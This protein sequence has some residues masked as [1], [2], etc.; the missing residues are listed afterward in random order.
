MPKT[1]IN[2]F[3]KPFLLLRYY[4]LYGGLGA[5]VF[6]LLLIFSFTQAERMA[7]YDQYIQHLTA[8]AQILYQDIDRDF[9]APRQVELGGLA[10]GPPALLRELDA[11]LDVLVRSDFNLARVKLFSA[12]GITLYDHEH[13]E[14]L[15]QRYAS[16]GEPGFQSALQGRAASSLEVDGNGR[17]MEICLPVLA[18]GT[19]RVLGVLELYEDVGRFEGQVYLAL[20]QALLA[21]TLIFVVFNLILAL[22][23][24]KADRIIAAET[25]L[26]HAIRQNMEK[27]LSR[28]AIEA[29][30]TAV[31]GKLHLFT[32]KRQSLVVWFS[33]IRGFTAFSEQNEPEKVVAE[34]NRIL[35]LQEEIIHREGGVVDKFIGDAV[36]ATFAA[37]AAESA[38]RVGL[39]V[40]A[41]VRGQKDLP[42]RLGIGIHA[43]DAVVGTIGSDARRDYT[44]IGDTVNT[45]SRLCG[46]ASPGEVVISGEVCRELSPEQASRFKPRHLSGL[47]G[48]AAAIEAF[49]C[50]GEEY[51]GPPLSG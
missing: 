27:Y 29:I 13:P 34:L 9:L 23:V 21:P 39:A 40:L 45:A 31:S 47:K 4:L 11:E 5:V 36:M 51:S 37:D 26:L 7:L 12:E 20:R 44:A 24:A 3:S 1:T 30:W 19:N 33:D 28:S 16:W 50:C 15:G 2:P 42:F 46:V 43:G 35:E 6:Y 10:Q 25:G 18:P 38:V 49:S 48:K 8:K 14:N 41:A 22:L 32:G 17:F